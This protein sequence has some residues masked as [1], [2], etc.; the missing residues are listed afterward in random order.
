VSND[1]SKALRKAA[2]GW[3]KDKDVRWQTPGELAATVNPKTVRTPALSM[4]DQALVKL[5]DTPDARLIISVAPQEGKSVRVAGDFPAWWLAQRPDAR[6][7][8]A[9]YSS[10]LAQRNGRAIRRRIMDHDL[11]I[12]IAD[13]NGAV[14]DWT[15]KGYDG[16]VLSVGVG[17]GLTGRPA[18][19]LIIDD[20]IKDR[21]EAD[22]QTFRDNNWSWWTDTASSRLAPGAPVVVILTRWHHD[23]LAGR[24]LKS[25]ASQDDENPDAINADTYDEYDPD[26]PLVPHRW[27]IL[28]I[29][30][31]ADFDPE[32]GEKDIL[33]RQPGEF[34][35]SA[36]RRTQD[37]WEAR[38]R[39]AGP[40]TWASLYQGK[41]TPGSGDMF[42]KEWC[43]YEHPV[44]VEMP[45]GTC[46]VPGAHE[47]VQSW[48]MTF[49]DT[50]SSDFVVGQVWARFG[51]DAYL[52]DQVRRRMGFKA[53]VE[54]VKALTARWPQAAAKFVEDKANGPA[55]INAL[56]RTVPGLIP[57]E[58][59]GSKFA[60][61]AAVSPFIHSGN[62][63]L[64]SAEI[65]PNV[66]NLL[67][68]A[69]Q[70]P[71]GAHDDTID[72]MSQ[73]INRLL[74]H[75]LIDPNDEYQTIEDMFGEGGGADPHAILGGY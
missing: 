43:R 1:L 16:G 23:D 9:S 40:Y 32:K 67:L 26:K 13:D 60:R 11:G 22:S 36:R 69:E 5:R 47:V 44:F 41:P 3:N 33:G 45:N 4:I 48:D 10:A 20:P 59:E 46:M 56:Q 75:P 7:V 28:N 42:P 74:L 50:D 55:V 73:A 49:K 61:A 71:S 18:D 52:V 38:K 62:V 34:M 53:T 14:H 27:T 25:D 63:I 17:A 66:Q 15:L 65:L 8:T 24:L 21:K 57:I 64:P 35:V 12:E 2:K 39:A 70:F 31:Q 54:A 51:T 68:E 58:P 37:Q 6:I 19:L 72:A 30:A 29:P